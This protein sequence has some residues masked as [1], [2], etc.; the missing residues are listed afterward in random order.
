[1]KLSVGSWILI[2]LLLAGV[3]TGIYF[4]WPKVN[5]AQAFDNINDVNEIVLKV[6]VKDKTVF[7]YA[8]ELQQMCLDN[9]LFERAS[10]LNIL[11]NIIDIQNNSQ[12]QV[13][14]ALLVIDKSSGKYGELTNKQNKAVDE[15]KIA[16][17][18]FQSYIK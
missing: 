13:F 7:D 9:E 4:L 1:M 17:K 18:D 10:K 2:I 8:D 3:G 6:D 12:K 11:N 16:F 15:C 5:F 14:G